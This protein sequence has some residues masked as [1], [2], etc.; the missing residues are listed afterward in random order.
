M[1]LLDPLAAH[2]L[3]AV[4]G[5]G[6]SGSAAARLLDRLGKRVVATDSREKISALDLP[7]QCDVRLGGLDIG[8]ARIV[9]LTPGLNPEWP[10]NAANP[11]LVPLIERARRGE[12]E[13]V[14]EIT[15]AAA[16]AGLPLLSI[17]G[18]DG[19][20][21]T[22]ALVHHLLRACGVD[23][24]LGGNS[25]TALADV[26]L[27]A[28]SAEIVVAE[29]SAFQLWEPHTLRPRG[30]AMTNIAPD[31][32]DHYASLDDYVAAKRHIT[33]NMAHG[34]H[35][36]AWSLD[37]R[38]TAFGRDARD[39]GVRFAS[40]AVDPRDLP[41]DA[42]ATAFIDADWF[43]V[44]DRSREHRVE[45][46]ALALPG[47]HNLRN[48][49][50]ALLHVCLAFVDDPRVEAGALANGLRS[51]RGLPHRV[52]WVRERA[53]VRFY[54]DSKATN[55]HAAVTGLRAFA[56]P[57]V[58]IVGGVDKNLDLTELLD[59]LIERSRTVIVIGEIRER[60][61]AEAATRGLQTER[62]SDMADA[63]GRAARAA[64]PGDV[65]VLAPACSSFDM[66][67][68]FEHRGDVFADCVRALSDVDG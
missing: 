55:V 17:G 47:A 63:V 22:A 34:D 43:V 56:E 3:I 67:T 66:F 1:R 2:D 61:C 11:Q 33:R 37:K 5:L 54:N 19:K 32:L 35:Y 46:A 27:A 16:A 18:T 24:I 13:L 60:F 45:R 62:A 51:F 59:V 8:D 30:A 9:V 57:I 6:A 15:L 64:R 20:S 25:W 21:T 41:A 14:S 65:V 39:R 44:R 29:I 28:Q 50:A 58:A 4:A 31:H 68:S 7:P 52:E 49:L 26:V 10:A 12:I 42:D 48:A 36:I 23:A 40:F 53:G 38:T